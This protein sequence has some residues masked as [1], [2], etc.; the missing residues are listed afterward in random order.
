M[1]SKSWSLKAL[2]LPL[3]IMP[4]GK[5]AQDEAHPAIPVEFLDT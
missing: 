1:N 4:S 2:L 5:E 3:S